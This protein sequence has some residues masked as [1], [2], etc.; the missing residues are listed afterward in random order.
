MVEQ[1]S[2]NSLFVAKL[3]QE[4]HSIWTIFATL[5]EADDSGN[6]YFFG[7]PLPPGRACRRILQVI[8]TGQ[9]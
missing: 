3:N 4:L 7:Q 9:V 8:L 2:S 5:P 1:S 6:F